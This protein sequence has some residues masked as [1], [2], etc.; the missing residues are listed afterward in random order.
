MAD[1]IRHSPKVSLF[2]YERTDIFSVQE[3]AQ[4]S[5]WHITA[6]HLPEAWAK[7]DGEGVV[8]AVLDTGCDLDHPD[9][10]DNLLPGYN[11]I[12]VGESPM[13]DNGHGTHV[14]GILI[15]SNNEVGVVGVAPKAKV[16]PIKV[17]DKNGNGIM[18]VVAAGIRKAI[19][20]KV[21]LISLSLGCP[22]P[23]P[24]VE[25]AIKEAERAGIPVFCAAGNAGNT[26]EV[27]YPAC[28]RTCI[29]IGAI[30]ENFQRAIFSNTGKNLDFMCPGVDI[31]STVPKH[32]YAM[33]SGTSMAQ[34]FACGVAALLKSAWKKYH[35]NEPCLLNSANEFREKLRQHTVPLK[36]EF[37]DPSFFG[38]FGIIDVKSLTFN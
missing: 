14:T 4:R 17:L 13:D 3:A 36:G 19:S 9:L 37:P 20:L 8:I 32:W 25:E 7:T 30:D 21:D 33:M 28:Y 6:F 18:T 5:G 29:A 10:I 35:P 12:K 38:G 11:M 31:L 23:I 2:P 24:M 34:P 27:F 15:A 22:I 26:S 16:V 1:L